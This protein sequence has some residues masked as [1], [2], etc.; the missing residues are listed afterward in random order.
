[1]GDANPIRTL[2]D[3]SKPSYK[4]YKN[5]IELLEGNNVVPL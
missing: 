4:G 2:G 5:T 1:M 3:Y